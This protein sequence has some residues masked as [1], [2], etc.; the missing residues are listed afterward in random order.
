M[1]IH[2][3]QKGPKKG[4]TR[5]SP[6]LSLGYFINR[7][8]IQLKFAFREIGRNIDFWPISSYVDVLFLSFVIWL[9]FMVH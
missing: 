7:P 4:G 3:D 1:L 8:E 2:L 9:I 5:F 6:E